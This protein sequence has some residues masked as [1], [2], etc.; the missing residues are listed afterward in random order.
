[1]SEQIDKISAILRRVDIFDNLSDVQYELIA[2]LCQPLRARRGEI[3]LREQERSDDLYIIAQGGVEVLVDPSQITAGGRGELPEE[4]V[5]A[6][7]RDGQVFGE[8]ALVDQ[9]VRSASVRVS[10]EDTQLFRIPRKQLMSL[11]DT[12]PELGYKLMK[13][14]AAELAFKIRDTALTFREY[15]IALARE[16]PDDA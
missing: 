5:L 16:R 4:R 13:N 1:M 15:Q 3:L 8:V 11:C 7:L 10:M 6:E 12:Y 9:G 14:L 2:Y